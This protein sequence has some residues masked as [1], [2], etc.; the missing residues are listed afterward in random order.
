MILLVY[1]LIFIIIFIYFYQNNKVITVDTFVNYTQCSKYKISKRLVDIFKKYNF[2]RSQS[3]LDWGLYLP[4]GYSNVEKELSLLNPIKNDQAVFAIDGCDKI[5]SKKSLWKVLK[6][7]YGPLYKKYIPP[8]Y[9]CS[10]KGIKEL[11]LYHRDNTKYIIKKDIQQQKGLEIIHDINILPE[12]I[13]DPSNIIIQ[14]LLDNPF[15]INRHK[16]NIRVYLLIIC[17]SNTVEAYIH[18]NGF[19]YYTPK[20]FDYKSSDKDAHITTGYIDRKIYD[21]NPLS[22]DDFRQYLQ[23]STYNKEVFNQNLLYF[24][25]KIMNALHIPVCNSSNLKNGV[26]FQLFGCDIAVNNRL[27][28]KLMEINKGPDLNSKSKRDNHIKHEI[29]LDVFEKVDLIR[30]NFKRNRFIKVK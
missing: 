17:K 22:T 5:V 29:I 16:I 14:E 20:P 19:I 25:K 8:T 9:D 15:T 28:I 4:C 3:N 1:Y 27:D 21:T 2:K 18:D 6:N 13:K 30:Q 7:V 10:L 12:K 11:L 26:A 23:N 24:F